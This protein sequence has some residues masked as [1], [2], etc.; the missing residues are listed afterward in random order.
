M[1]IPQECRDEEQLKPKRAKE[2]NSKKAKVGNIE[3][4]TTVE[5]ITKLKAISMKRSIRLINLKPGES[6]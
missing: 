6:R 4:R 5:K 1:L 2:R 3:N